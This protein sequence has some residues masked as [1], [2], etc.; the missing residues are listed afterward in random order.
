MIF[1]FFFLAISNLISNDNTT[2]GGETGGTTATCKTGACDIVMIIFGCIGACLIVAYIIVV[3]RYNKQSKEET[4][5]IA[6]TL[7]G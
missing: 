1:F 4:A 7:V 5:P 3:V 6:T 2:T